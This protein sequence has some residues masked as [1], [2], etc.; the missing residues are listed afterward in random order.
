MGFTPG[1]AARVTVV[2]VVLGYHERMLA[3]LDRLVVLGDRV[4]F[5][6]VC[7]VNGADLSESLRGQV[8][9]G[10]VVLEQQAN[11][12]WVGGLHAART[13]LRGEYMAWMQDDIVPDQGW[14]DAA[15]AALDADASLGI[16]GSVVCGTDGQPNGTQAGFTPVGQAARDWR[17][18]TVEAV[19][20]PSSVTRCAWVSSGGAVT[21][22][23][24]WDELGGVDVRMYPLGFVDFAYCAH[25]RTHGWGVALSPG[26]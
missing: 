4:P 1:G 10:V 14:L 6:V 20:V 12:G 24:V 16:V 5:D 2:L 3:C 9:D 17:L 25:A 11:L 18:S 21:R 19:D 23:S 26:A 15:V 7:V 13:S 22:V 8:P